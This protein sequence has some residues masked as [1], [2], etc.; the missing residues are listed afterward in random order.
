MKRFSMLFVILVLGVVLGIQSTSHA[1]LTLF[2]DDHAGHTATIS[3]SNADGVVNYSGNLGGWNIASSV[4]LSPPFNGTMSK[5]EMDLSGAF[6]YTGGGAGSLTILASEVG[7]GP[8]TGTVTFFGSVS[9][10]LPT[11]MSANFKYW[12]NDNNALFGTQS[13]LGSTIAMT[14]PGGFSS[15]SASGPATGDYSLT[16]EADFPATGGQDSSASFD[17]NIR[18]PEPTTLILLGSGLAALGIWTRRR[19]RR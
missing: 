1:T 12:L 2:L 15:G 18:A 16:V 6:K 9:S 10:T 4:A 5:P 8:A 17:Q 14:Y 3:D 11:N 19:F 7:F 13:Q